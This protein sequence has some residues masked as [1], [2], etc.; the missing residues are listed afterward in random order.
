MHALPRF[1]MFFAEVRVGSF[2]PA[3]HEIIIQHCAN[4]GTCDRNNSSRPLL[5]KLSAGF[6]GDLLNDPRNELIDDIFLQQVST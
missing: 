1:K 6:S 5:Y 4:R 3:A 2:A